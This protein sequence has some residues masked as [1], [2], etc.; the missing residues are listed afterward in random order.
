[1][2]EMW[3]RVYCKGTPCWLWHAIDHDTGDVVAFVL[4]TRTKKMCKQLWDMLKS[5]NIEIVQV[6]SDDNWAYH[7]IIPK[8]LLKTGKRNTQKIERKHLTFRARLKRLA[9]KTICF[10][11]IVEMHIIMVSM[12]IN[13]LEFNVQL[14]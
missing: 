7:D 11:K 6:Y 8:K 3:G 14:F 9:R 2:D 1:M 12:L 13:Y 5:L 4:G 10:S